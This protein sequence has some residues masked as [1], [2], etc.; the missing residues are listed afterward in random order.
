[1]PSVLLIFLYS[2]NIGVTMP[3]LQQCQ[4][5]DSTKIS[6]TMPCLQNYHF[7]ATET[8]NVSSMASYQTLNS[9]F[10]TLKQKWCKQPCMWVCVY[11]CACVYAQVCIRMYV[12]VCMH[13]CV[14]VC[15]CVCVHA[16]MCMFH[17]ALDELL[18]VVMSVSFIFS[19][20]NYLCIAYFCVIKLQS[21]LSCWNCTIT[22]YI[23]LSLIC[24]P[25]IW[26]H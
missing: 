3:C 12:C 22:I 8:L 6:V 1:M 23:H 15:M 16:C 17:Y 4:H 11:V 14:C 9:Y 24:Q 10:S 25:N 20:C 2:T 26:C 21:S 7:N 18:Y 13:A 5:S 19:L